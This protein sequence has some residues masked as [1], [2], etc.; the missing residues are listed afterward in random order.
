M[1][2]TW[3]GLADTALITLEELVF[4]PSPLL[5]SSWVSFGRLLAGN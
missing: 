3:I 4:I 1:V 2:G 5:L